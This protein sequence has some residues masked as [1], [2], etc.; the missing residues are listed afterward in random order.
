MEKKLH[1][2]EAETRASR[3]RVA[4]RRHSCYFTALFTLILHPLKKPL[5]GDPR[6]ALEGEAAS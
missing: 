3:R 4:E 5:D 6:V 1:A 2:R